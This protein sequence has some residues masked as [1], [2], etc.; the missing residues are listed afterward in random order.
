[1]NL[2]KE[3]LS[4]FLYRLNLLYSNMVEFLNKFSESTTT[5]KDIIE[6]DY[7]TSDGTK[8]TSE[9]PSVGSMKADI[10]ALNKQI[11]SLISV[12]DDTLALE[13]EDGS[14][15]K[16]DMKKLSQLV[17]DL[18]SIEDESFTVPTSFRVKNNWF[19]ESFLNPLLYVTVNVADYVDGGNVDKFSVK[20]IILNVESDAD[21]AFFDNSLS[22][23]S[24]LEYE[25]VITELRNAGIDF[26]V[27]DNIVDMPTSINQ[28]RGNFSV[29]NIYE[30]DVTD[31]SGDTVS[32]RRYELDKLTYR[33]LV[34]SVEITENL[35]VDDILITSDD[36]EYKILSI[37]TEKR[38]VTLEL[39]F[40]SQPINIGANSLK[41]KPVPFRSPDLNI[42]MSFDERTVI[43]VRPISKTLNMSTEKLS[44]GFAVYSNDLVIN[45]SDDQ[46]VNLETYYRNFV[47][48]FG[49]ILL[50]FAKERQVPAVDGVTPD[51]PSL[52][53]TDFKVSWINRHIF[54][55]DALLQLKEKI[56]TKEKL[57]SE[58]RESN[59][60]INDLKA[61]LNSETINQFQKQKIEKD[62]TDEAN[63]KTNL[64]NQLSTIVSEITLGLKS[65]T[66]FQ[67]EP[68]YRVRG[69]FDIPDAKTITG[70]TQEVI[71]FIVS[72]RYLSKKG[73]SANVDQINRT[74]ST[75][76]EKIDFYSPWTEVYTK[77]RSKEYDSDSG[78]YIWSEEDTQNAEV[79]NINQVD[80]PIKANEAVE[81]RVKSISEAGFP[82]NPL[83]SSWSNT[84]T[85]EFPED[86]ET[87][88]DSAVLTQSLLQE[89]T[90]VQFESELNAR[91][92]DVHLLN[93][94]QTGDK[95]YGHKLTD[96]ASGFFTNEGNIIDAFEV[97]KSMRDRI[98]AL[99]N[100]IEQDKGILKVSLTLPNGYVREVKRG[101]VVSVFAGYYLDD[102]KVE[103]ETQNISYNHG[104]IAEKTYILTLQNT[105]KTPLELASRLAGGIDQAVASTIDG[106]TDYNV[107]RKYAEVP[108]SVITL[109]DGEVGGFKHK[110]PYQSGHAKSM[111]IYNRYK[112]Y[113]LSDDLYAD[114]GTEEVFYRNDSGT[115]YAYDGSAGS[116]DL[117]IPYNEGMY[118]PYLPGVD[119]GG[120]GGTDSDV[121]VGTNSVSPGTA[122]GDGYLTEFC[123]H[124]D[125]PDIQTA[126]ISDAEDFD[127]LLFPDITTDTQKYP[128]ISHGLYFEIE[129]GG[130][131]DLGGKDYQQVAYRQVTDDTDVISNY[132]IKLGFATNDE[133]LIGKYTCGAYL[134]MGPSI[135]EDVSID[136][137]HP[138]LAKRVIEFG[139]ESSINIP[140]IFQY[141]CSDK[142]EYV[143]GYRDGGDV[144]SNISYKKKI[145]FDIYEKLNT[146]ELSADYGDI[147]SFD[148]EV[149]CRYSRE[150]ATDAPVSVSGLNSESVVRYTE[151]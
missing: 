28:N 150:A 116:P 45:L 84:I 76:A 63:R 58:I 131:N 132:P 85:I 72:Y 135:Y 81:I 53:T 14:V 140:I 77:I 98:E 92:L 49:S 10:T 36:T 25:T 149:T 123:I 142:L 109:G 129:S 80:I 122:D 51:A 136:G 133:Y 124:V 16:F 121:W 30:E 137:N 102:I 83:T 105:S 20:K 5:S 39:Q 115:G 114:V 40:G 12:N 103:T 11:Q 75:G 47:S 89:E 127:D 27:D 93:A 118:L 67:T 96:L 65:N 107:N 82:I 130:T 52:D 32:R 143:G 29:I 100:A 101:E 99:E 43:F 42:N 86:L 19:F 112:N 68:K 50:N 69:F 7:W 145:G 151:V 17:D 94:V 147:F 117:D 8:N 106:D 44:K 74:D 18:E 138:R 31:D 70:G 35:K 144:L 134:F 95:Y 24:D 41:I 113:G 21:I 33:K 6:V 128:L 37:D 9:I 64:S 62:I 104:Q 23:R 66:Q 38:L 3:N 79:V 46:Q 55:D 97:I 22:G 87:Q 54:E 119:H 110:A 2:K 71:Q 141:R 59:K 34:D 78:T 60:K 1:M 120:G 57:Q 146:S 15:K 111:F 108:L 56:A 148:L 4:E 13:F 88:N 125:H 126:T 139:S 48:D 91:G 61:Q 73:T 26:V 90:R